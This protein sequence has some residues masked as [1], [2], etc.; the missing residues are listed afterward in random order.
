M[1]TDKIISQAMTRVQ[2]QPA[3]R[4]SGGRNANHRQP[5]GGKVFTHR[6]TTTDLEYLFAED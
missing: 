2:S 6:L 1:K 5:A 4:P 3:S